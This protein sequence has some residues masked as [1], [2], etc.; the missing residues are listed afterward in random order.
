MT[1]SSRDSLRVGF[2][3]IGRKRPGFSP[4]YLNEHLFSPFHSTKKGGLGIG[5]V[6]CKSLVEAH[7]GT[8]KISNAP[9]DGAV[10]TVR[11]PRTNGGE[12]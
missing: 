5:L 8:L 10:V 9:D 3:A 6:L 12:G 1:D 2:L 4:E 7:G 11:L